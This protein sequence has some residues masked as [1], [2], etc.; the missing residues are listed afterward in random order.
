MNRRLFV[1]VAMIA[2]LLMTPS[3]PQ[4]FAGVAERGTVTLAPTG[5]TQS[6]AVVQKTVQLKQATRSG[7]RPPAGVIFNNPLRSDRSHTINSHIRAAIANTGRGEKIRMATWNFQSYTY[8]TA[9]RR[10]HERGVS[11]RIIMARSLAREQTANGP[12]ATLRR[13][14]AQGNGKRK[15]SRTSW[16][17]TCQNSCRGKS[18]SAHSKYAL[19]TKSGQSEDVVMQGS[20][21]LTNSAAFA[22]WN[23]LYTVAERPKI[24]RTFNAIFKESAKDRPT[25][26]TFRI[27]R[28]GPIQSWF[29][30][31]GRHSDLV[32][33]MLNRVRCQGAKNAGINGRTSIRVAQAVY[34]GDRGLRIARKLKELHRQGCNIRLVYTLMAGRSREALAGVPKKQLASDTD[35]DGS[36][37]RYVHMKA[38]AISGNYA[39]DRS[40][41]IVLNGSA[42]WSGTGS[43]SD[44][45]G[46]IIRRASV[47]RAYGS[48]INQLFRT[49]VYNAKP[50]P[51]QFR[52]SDP[53]QDVELD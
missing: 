24:Y 11:V 28:D 33:N 42:N 26:K 50:V 27:V 9:L 48:W 46:M 12:Y 19:F 3:G 17:R 45:Q 34:N 22:Q 43:N 15:Q 18:G 44:E 30:P 6:Q 23:D 29:H 4:A 53:Y 37:D 20:A 40:A 32:L 35:G 5:P 41:R 38:M 14:L 2:A 10:A 51:G 36:F 13:A 7:Y 21:N 25:R 8:V 49:P 1:A 31:R 39:G 16:F 52:V 47:E